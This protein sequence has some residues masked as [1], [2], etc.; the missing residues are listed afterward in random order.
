M[1]D[2]PTLAKEMFE[3]F[4]IMQQLYEM[5]CYLNEALNLEDAQPIYKDLQKAL[6]ETERLT[7]QNPIFLLDL[8]L[9][10]HRAFVNDLLLQTS[11]LVRPKIKKNIDNSKLSKLI[12]GKDFVGAKLRG[13]NFRGTNLRGVLFIASDLREADMSMTDLIGADF[14]RCGS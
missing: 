5:L 9:P 4:P 8:H 11:E 13:A 3:V 14:R 10:T 6:V 12:R 1:A 2:N 7:N